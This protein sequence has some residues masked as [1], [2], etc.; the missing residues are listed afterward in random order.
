VPGRT[1]RVQYKNG[2]DNPDWTEL[3]GDVVAT[4]AT[5]A[6]LDSAAQTTAARFYRVMALR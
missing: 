4:S 2:I 1:Y 3:Q 6:K 5:G